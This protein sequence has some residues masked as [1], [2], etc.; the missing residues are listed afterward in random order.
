MASRL[1]AWDLPGHG[2]AEGISELGMREAADLWALMEALNAD[3]PVVL[4]GWSLGAG[5][6]IV[7]GRRGAAAVIAEAP[8]REAETP[9]RNVLRARGLPYR[10]TVKPAVGLVEAL[11][12]EWSLLERRRPLFDRAAYAAMLPCPLLVVHGAE[13][14][15]CPIEDG[16]AIANSAPDGRIA[17]IAG[18]GHNDLWT[19]PALAARCTAAVRDFL[20]ESLRTPR[21]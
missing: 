5:V 13:D 9:A 4:M 21:S 11:G 17:E 2:E 16:R 19:E 1:V 7:C 8:Y 10:T 20:A 14:E 18:A 15:V 12:R 3:R 6:S